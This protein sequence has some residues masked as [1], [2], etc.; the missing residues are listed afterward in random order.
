MKTFINIRTLFVFTS[1]LL[2]GAFSM[3]LRALEIGIY[4]PPHGGNFRFH[5]I[6]GS[7]T[8]TLIDVVIPD[9]CDA[10]CK[11][12][13][14]SAEINA[15]LGPKY[16]KVNPTGGILHPT[17]TIDD[18]TTTLVKQF[19][20]TGERTAFF[21]PLNDAKKEKK[22]TKIA[23]DYHL[24]EGEILNGIDQNGIESVF[25]SSFGYGNIV[26]AAIFSFS[27]LSGNTIDALLTDTY[28]GFL[29]DL[30]AAD[31]ANLSLDLINDEINFIFPDWESSG[32]VDTFTSDTNAYASM[33]LG[34]TTIPEPSLLS[35]M[36]IAAIALGLATKRSGKQKNR[37]PTT[38][39]IVN[40][41]TLSN[42]PII[43]S[44]AILHNR[45]DSRELLL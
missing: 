23:V 9:G 11:A 17:I 13:K 44:E 25:Q 2:V 29:A 3:P 14:V 19:D 6:Q 35:L 5:L 16:S 26:A 30:T 24:F 8:D 18:T 36:A 1:M 40:R 15:K 41:C 37:R 28:N 43:F 27:D 20:G 22:I 45:A 21:K 10:I 34:T 4:E 39:S 31:S 7:G 12:N 32:F 42:R 38:I 33:S